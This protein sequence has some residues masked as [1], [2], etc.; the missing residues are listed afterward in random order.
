MTQ[1]YQTKPSIVEAVQWNGVKADIAPIVEWVA[2]L[3]GEAEFEFRSHTNEFGKLTNSIKVKFPKD[4]AFSLLRRD[5]L[6][7]GTSGNMSRYTDA[8]FQDLYELAG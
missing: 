3:G 4:S 2:D 1:K 8:E 5:W 7:R 6:V